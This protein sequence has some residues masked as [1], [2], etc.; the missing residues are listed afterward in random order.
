MVNVDCYLRC[1]GLVVVVVVYKRW[2]GC[3][4]MKRD[5]LV[6]CVFWIVSEVGVEIVVNVE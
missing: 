6:F 1:L 5:R 2:L 4:K 3:V